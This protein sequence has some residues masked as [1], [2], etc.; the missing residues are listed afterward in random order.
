MAKHRF[1]LGTKFSVIVTIMSILVGAFIMYSA[2]QIYNRHIF[3]LYDIQANAVASTAA[4]IINWD[5]LENYK[6]T[7]ITDKAYEETLRKLRLCAGAGDVAYIYFFVPNNNELMFIYDTDSGETQGKL[8]D[9]ITW[10][11]EFG[12]YVEDAREIK[13]LGPLFSNEENYGHLLSG[14]VPYFD[15]SNRFIGYLGIDFDIEKLVA[16]Q[17]NFLF[18]LSI[19][20]LCM[21]LLLTLAFIAIM[22]KMV[23]NPINK[24]S[25]AANEYLYDASANI[26]ED[27]SITKLEI[28]TGDELEDLSISLKTMESKIKDYLTNLEAVRR[29][30]QTDSLTN[31]LNRETFEKRVSKLLKSNVSNGFYIYIIIDLDYFKTINDTY[32]HN[33]GDQVLIAVSDALKSCFRATDS[34]A[35]LGGDEFAI[36]YHSPAEQKSVE[37]RVKRIRK[38]ISDI[39]VKEDITITVSMGVS[40]FSKKES[41]AYK[42]FYLAADKALYEVKDK[43]RDGYAIVCKTK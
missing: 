27:N 28:H 10:E 16:E 39:R 9:T 29:K 3:E 38:A 13:R 1:T 36:F 40:I 41:P 18:Q 25:T 2:Y 5:N 23:I 37:D 31:I 34:I 12:N 30:A 35:R 17:N 4:E 21:T 6:A 26:S 15:T 11:E 43:G 42:D 24:T 14:Y 19:A 32:G 7:P 33:I 20:T 8:G 22:R